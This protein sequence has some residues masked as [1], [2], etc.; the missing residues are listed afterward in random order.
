MPPIVIQMQPHSLGKGLREHT[1]YR[2]SGPYVTF[3]M[4]SGG[5]ISFLVTAKNGSVTLAARNVAFYNFGSFA[6]YPN[7]SSGSIRLDL[8]KDLL[9]DITIQSLDSALKMEDY[10]GGGEINT[11]MLK[12]GEYVLSVRYED[13][14]VDQQRII[15]SK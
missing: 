3:N 5:T 9:F 15:V 10:R 14:V 6:V 4:T 2:T 1:A 7:P 12:P 8:S 11:S 13:K